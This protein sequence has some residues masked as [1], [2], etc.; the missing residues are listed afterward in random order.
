MITSNLAKNAIA[1]ALQLKDAGIQL[2]AADN[3]AMAELVDSSMPYNFVE[4]GQRET[5]VLPGGKVLNN[6]V[7]SWTLTDKEMFGD[8]VVSATGNASEVSDHTLCITA[9]ADDLAPIITSHIYTVRSVVIPLVNEFETPAQ[10]FLDLAAAKDPSAEFSIRMLRIPALLGDAS[11]SSMGLDDIVNL[12]EIRDTGARLTLKLEDVDAVVAEICNL[13][14]ARLN[15][16]LA[17]WLE[18]APDNLIKNVLVANFTDAGNFEEIGR[19][20]FDQYSIR[21]GNQGDAMDLSLAM[22]L[23]ANWLKINVKSTKENVTLDEYAAS[24]QY[25]LDVAGVTLKAALDQLGRQIENGILVTSLI[26]NRKEVT[27][28]DRLYRVYLEKGGKSEALLG[29]LMAGQ[30]YFDMNVIL[31]NQARL[32]ESWNSY[33]SFR[34]T[35]DITDIRVNFQAWVRSYMSVAI[36]NQADIECEYE[37]TNPGMRDIIMKN[38]DAEI[39]HLSHRLHEDIAHTALHMVAKA[40]FF[41][42]SAYTIL[43]EMQQVARFNKDIDPREAAAAATITYLVEYLYSQVNLTTLLK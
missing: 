2:T 35:K 25:W 17:D 16:L 1:V 43:S 34:A 24:F 13:G 30:G 18:N 10:A 9:L 21:R 36:T 40:R 22:W 33:I 31:E 7:S 20:V 23:I 11:F 12:A 29:M 14:N 42:T 6:N 5:T 4:Q 38:V 28:H 3:S 27:V 37:K 41:Y 19:F 15:G 32:V 8:A 39:M 26:P